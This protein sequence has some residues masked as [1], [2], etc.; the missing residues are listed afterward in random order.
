MIWLRKATTYFLSVILLLSLLGVALAT[1]ADTAFSHPAKIETWLSQSNIY[2]HFVA[3]V[4]SQAQNST[5]GNNSSVALTD[6][7]VQQAAESAFTPQL[8]QQDASI[9]LNSNYAWLEG[10][11]SVPNF[12]I[13]LG[14]AKQTFAQ[15]VGSYVTTY[16]NSLPACT[17]AQLTQL[18]SV[19]NADPLSLSCR[20]A[21]LNPQTEGAQV[22]QQLATSSSFLSD[23]VL[24]ADNISPTQNHQVRQPYYQRLASA[25]KLY[26]AAVHLPLVLTIVALLSAL[27]I[28][29][30]AVTRRRGLRR[31]GEVL[32]IA[33]ILL[34]LVKF[35]ADKVF[36]RLEKQVFNNS[37]VGQ[38]QQSLTD[39][40]HRVESQLVKVDLWFGVGFVLF[41]VIILGYLLVTR[42]RQPKTPKPEKLPVPQADGRVETPR[43][44]SKPPRL[45]Q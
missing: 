32:L 5:G 12:S 16:L 35:V 11:T 39:F 13:N 31:I 4:T 18:G 38:L 7:A 34:M 10:K 30:M 8:L 43:P 22:T 25:P 41:A 1:S 27:G 2:N 37:S 28:S 21:T 17:T 33:G 45:I 23:P 36:N 3:Q 42:R 9:F 6:V 40:A 24:T 15:T 19:Q 26:R 20:P 29:F 14:P 44:T